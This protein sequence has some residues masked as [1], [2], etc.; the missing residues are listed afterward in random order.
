MTL[1][2][3]FPETSLLGTQNPFFESDM[4]MDPL[5]RST[6][7]SMRSLI[8]IDLQETDNAYLIK[9]DLPGFK[10]NQIEINAEGSRLYISANREE[11]KEEKEAQFHRRERSN[12][13]MRRSVKLPMDI[14]SD[15]I[16]AKM[17][18]GVLNLTVPKNP[19]AQAK[20]ITVM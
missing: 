11:T 20:K 5:F 9:A 15:K 13:S 1:A 8:S 12:Q 6:G 16:K 4:V 10:K 17:A 18:D 7:P 2:R 19:K 14:D 3:F